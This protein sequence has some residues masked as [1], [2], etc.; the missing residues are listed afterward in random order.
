MIEKSVKEYR[1]ELKSNK[2]GGHGNGRIV[3]IIGS[4]S[5]ITG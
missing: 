5:G 2:K 3:E 1:I 4:C